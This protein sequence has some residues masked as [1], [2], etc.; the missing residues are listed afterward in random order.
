MWINQKEQSSQKYKLCEDESTRNLV[1]A[2]KH[3]QDEVFTRVADRLRD[4]EDQ[5][6]SSFLSA[7]YYYHAQCKRKYMR[8]FIVQTS[9][10]DSEHE[11][12]DYE[13]KLNLFK[14]AVPYFDALINT[15]DCCTMSD[16]VGFTLTLDEEGE[17]LSRTMYNRDMKKLLLDHYGELNTIAPN[18]Q[19]NEPDLFFSSTITAANIAVKLKNQ[20]ILKEA[21]SQIREALLK[22][23]FG[24]QD[25]F[26]DS[27]DLRE[28]WETTPI[29]DCLL[30]FY[31]VLYSVP[32]YKLF[33]TAARDLDELVNPILEEDSG[34]GESEEKS[35]DTEN[36]E[37]PWT[38]DK[39]SYHDILSVSA[40]VLWIA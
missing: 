34:N 40:D 31:S 26:C 12:K 20:D 13:I 17:V 37:H 6:A 4:N 27:N 16:A 35:Y 28:S 15:G 21:A 10:S 25:S 8:D 23:D 22:V 19:A 9:S 5:C 2:I 32:K 33:S 24:L 36:D 11:V 1:R 29:P 14:R 3:K 39:K 18:T 30:T 7:D 38:G